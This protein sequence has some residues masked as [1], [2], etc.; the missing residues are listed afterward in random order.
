MLC[1]RCGKNP[2]TVMYTQIINGQKSSVSICSQC[3]AQ[4]SVFDNFGSLLSFAPQ[5]SRGAECPVCKTT[6]D[7]FMRSGRAG[8]GTCYSLFRGQAKAMLRKIHGTARHTGK[9]S[10]AQQAHDRADELR[11]RMNEAVEEEKFEEAAALR[12]EL[13]ALEKEGAKHDEP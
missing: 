13:R 5:S 1:E 10:S 6:L 3:A 9:A 4:E 12:D 8:C 2:A 7:E 11:R